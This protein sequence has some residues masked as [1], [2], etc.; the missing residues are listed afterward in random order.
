[1]S[2]GPADETSHETARY[3]ENVLRDPSGVGYTESTDYRLTLNPRTAE[4]AGLDFPR[5]IERRIDRTGLIKVAP[6]AT[7]G[8][9][10]PFGI[11]RHNPRASA[12]E[13]TRCGAFDDH[14]II[15]N[16]FFPLGDLYLRVIA[17]SSGPDNH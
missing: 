14:P 8:F 11:H 5:S 13:G 3:I 6:H 2:Y 1:M 12:A 17:S 15:L 4:A 9:A 7:A 16:R 10:N